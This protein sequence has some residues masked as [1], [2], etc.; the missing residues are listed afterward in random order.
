MFAPTHLGTYSISFFFLFHVPCLCVS[1]RF[2]GDACCVV[3]Y[4]AAM[5]GPPRQT[6]TIH[7]D[8]TGTDGV[9][10]G[11]AKSS[12]SA[13]P[14][15]ETHDGINAV[16][17]NAASPSATS[18]SAGLFP[19][20][21]TFPLSIAELQ[22]LYATET[23]DEE[24]TSQVAEW[25]GI[26]G[27]MQ[28]LATAPTGLDADTVAA[29]S[30]SVM[31]RVAVY[32][33]NTLPQ[34][35]P[36]TFLDFCLEVLED[37]M[38]RVLMIAAAISI[39]LGCI[40]DP[41]AGWHDGAAIF[42]AVILVTLVSALNNYQQQ[43][44]FA[45]VDVS[46]ELD[47]VTVIRSGR[48][49]SVDPSELLVG[50]LVLLAAGQRIPCDGIMVQLKGQSLKVNESSQTGETGLVEKVLVTKPLL[51][52][53]TEV[54][55]GSCVMLVLLVGINT[56]Y[57]QTMAAL[58]EEDRQTPLQRKLEYVAKLVGYMGL[59]FACATFIALLI[60]WIIDVAH[61][62]ATTEKGSELL[63]YALVCV[64]IIV[65][66][67]PEGLPLAVTVSLAYSMKSMLKDNILVR[68]LAACET[69][70]NATAVCSDKTGTLTQNRMTVLRVFLQQQQ[71]E[72]PP[73]RED[74]HP[75]VL[76]LL[77]SAIILNSAAWIEEEHV[78]LAVPPQ[79]WRWKDGN[80][81]EVALLAWLI[82]YGYDVNASR[83]KHAPVLRASE[84][85][86]SIKKYSSIVVE[87]SPEEM[88][89][90]GGKRYR[91][92]FKGAAEAIIAQCST[93]IDREGRAVPLVAQ[94]GN[95][96]RELLDTVSDFSRRGLR[97]IGC[98]YRDID[99]VPK[100]KD[101]A[102]VMDIG[103][104]SEAPPPPYM[105]EAEEEAPIT[106]CTLICMAG[107]SDPLRPTSYRSVRLCQRA[108]I[109]VRMVT[110]DH[111]E[112][113][114]FISRECGIWTSKQHL[115]MTGA[116]FRKM[117]AEADEET[118]KHKIERLRVLARSSP[119]DKQILVKFLQTQGHVVAAT[120]DGT[121]DAPALKSADVGIAMFQSGTAVCK[122]AADLWLLDDNFASIVAA[123]VWG[124]SVFDNIRKFLSFQL[125]VNVVA[126][127]L[128]LIGAVSHQPPPLN[129]VQL[130]WINLIMDTAAAV[131][132]G[133]E[134]PVA[135]ELLAR[136]PKPL[137][138]PL[139]SKP[140]WYKIFS[141]A[142]FQL[143]VL[144]FLL[145]GADLIFTDMTLKSTDHITLIFNTFT[146]MQ[147]GNWFNARRVDPAINVYSRMFNNAYYILIVLGAMGMQV[148][149]VE[150]FGSFAKTTHQTWGRWVCAIVVGFFSQP[151]GIFFYFLWQAI[152]KVHPLPDEIVTL[153][154]DSFE[155][156]HLQDRRYSFRRPDTA[157]E[158]SVRQ[159]PS[160]HGAHAINPLDLAPHGP[161]G[162]ALSGQS[163]SRLMS[164]MS[165]RR[166]AT[167]SARR[168][169][170]GAAVSFQAVNANP[171]PTRSARG[172]GAT[173]GELDAASAQQL[174]AAAS[175]PR[176]SATQ[177]AA[178]Q[179][180]AGEDATTHDTTK[181]KRVN[182]KGQGSSVQVIDELDELI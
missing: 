113:A 163:S 7:V 54:V 52:G 27:L 154:A 155:G 57:G 140:M 161:V 36:K 144:L 127:F 78:D 139:I 180:G 138:G 142:A 61:T 44:Q 62:S 150:V 23:S 124:R 72:R 26:P 99:E 4:V 93:Q 121:N 85:F 105:E 9:E 132:L 145:Y 70:G 49:F 69:M 29:E 55:S 104:T 146:W 182:S 126:L 169:T 21:D 148:L 28:K 178:Q 165:A 106:D 82:G 134:Q 10:L 33:T 110:G 42:F 35:E 156:A 116:E 100:K 90:Q 123:V 128:S 118:K 39:I 101:D 17:K 25:G 160:H 38:L 6:V 68:E 98:A 174:A 30:Q 12:S 108:G 109:I 170:G 143:T 137:N 107:L 8:E 135:E 40:D 50:D 18:P 97:V 158:L 164:S 3:Y 73:A 41:E 173:A 65:V 88:A 77:E 179:A 111:V 84:A 117:M 151:M 45:A 103:S 96:H 83:A 16:V 162:Q 125:T 159:R 66:A 37:I 102:A 176:L 20:S 157:E 14:G 172:E 48:Q 89:A 112:T 63:D 114:R 87:R 95:L 34:K 136:A 32:G 47:P 131:A 46:K 168:S 133:T 129:T 64:S 120:G 119:Q 31:E 51:M 171:N 53:G 2:L 92:F 141:Q 60:Y 59:G 130:L 122:S 1:L 91:Q 13:S 5:S 79:D 43:K 56:S 74:V 58:V 94:S 71:L 24:A 115:C 152:N 177:Q 15:G 75:H 86:D 76:R 147:I 81:T 80:Q 167:G 22:R 153:N 175:W 181:T 11:A 166:A 67:V 149:M 19:A